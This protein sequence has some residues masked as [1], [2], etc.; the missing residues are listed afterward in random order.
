MVVL[1]LLY[2]TFEPKYTEPKFIGMARIRVYRK[3]YF[4]SYHTETHSLKECLFTIPLGVVGC[5]KKTK[6]LNM[7]IN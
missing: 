3:S 1:F 2:T 7:L 4:F 6:H 5:L